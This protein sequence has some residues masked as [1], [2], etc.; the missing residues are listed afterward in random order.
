[1]VARTGFEY[2]RVLVLRR[3]LEEIAPDSF[4]LLT[5]AGLDKASGLQLRTQAANFDVL[6]V[7]P[8]RH[9]D[10]AFVRRNCAGKPVVFDPLIGNYLTRVIDYG[11]WWRRPFAYLRDR[12][13]FG[14]ADALLFD[15]NAHCA[16]TMRKLGFD[17]SH[18]YTLYIGAD[19]HLLPDL[20]ASRTTQYRFPSNEQ[21]ICVGFYGT[22]VPLQGVE[23]IIEAMYR[24]RNRTDICFELIGDH[25]NRADLRRL[26]EQYPN[27]QAVYIDYLPFEELLSRLHRY[28]LCLGIFGSSMKA[29]V[30]IPN[31]VYHYAALGKPIIS[32]DTLAMREVF[33]HDLD[34]CLIAAGSEALAEAIVALAED[35]RRREKLGT[36][37]AARIR[38]G[39]DPAGIAQSFLQTLSQITGLPSPIH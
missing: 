39:L 32:R 7:P 12:Y 27:S 1:M 33:T 20:S 2:N 35:P 8:F 18:C 5:L 10:V 22:L 19:T 38:D 37:A 11:W 29:E 23:V 34:A 30:V 31:K 9:R 25:G 21:P 6:Y 16:W 15:T 17:E 14:Q 24:L 28:D 3:G 13:R 36:A 4:E 26:R